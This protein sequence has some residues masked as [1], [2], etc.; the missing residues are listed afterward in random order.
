MNTQRTYGWMLG[1]LAT[2]G[3]IGWTGVAFAGDAANDVLTQV[4]KFADLN[5]DTSVGASTLYRRIES[6][7]DRVCGGPIDVRELA[8]AVRLK[9]CKEQAIEGAV[10]SVNSTVLT[11]IHLA[12]TGRAEKPMTLARVSQ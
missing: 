12:K 5:L 7:A 8:F 10:K 9:S 3:A 6:A 4:V 11:S 1:L 2:V